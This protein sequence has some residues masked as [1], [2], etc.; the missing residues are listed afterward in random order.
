MRRGEA[1]QKWTPIRLDPRIVGGID[2]I[3]RECRWR[4]RRTHGIVEI[5]LEERQTGR[6][7]VHLTLIEIARG[8]S[9]ARG[10]YERIGR[11]YPMSTNFELLNLA[12]S[13]A[14]EVADS[15]HMTDWLGA[16]SALVMTSPDDEAPDLVRTAFSSMSQTLPQASLWAIEVSDTLRTRL[17]SARV[18]FGLE[19]TPEVI[20]KAG[21]PVHFPGARGLQTTLILGYEPYVDP[22]LLASAPY[23]HGTSTARAG[24]TVV[25]LFGEPLAGVQQPTD[26]IQLFRSR[27]MF[28]AELG[29]VPRPNLASADVEAAIRWWVKGMNHLLGVL[30]DPAQY[31][32][33]DGYFDVRPHPPCTRPAA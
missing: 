25:I 19:E 11:W 6:P 17:T 33:S 4:V 22:V 9:P 8:S 18:L 1:G 3:A 28:D 26:P 16:F 27:L 13:H 5:R 23:I 21:E 30:L 29:G 31:V 20:P 12:R 2:R 14:A 10:D 32:G 24:G 15:T 7:P